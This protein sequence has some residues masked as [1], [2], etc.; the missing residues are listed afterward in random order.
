MQQTTISGQHGSR[1]PVAEA[2]WIVT[3][4]FVMIA[5]GDALTLL[6]LAFAIVAMTT[7]WLTYRKVKH[8]VERN[9]AEMALVPHLRP[10]LTGKRDLKKTSAHA[11]WRGPNAA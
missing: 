5:F 4:V 10:A 1:Y 3:G 9:D 6:V 8:R 7:A 2:L 11:S